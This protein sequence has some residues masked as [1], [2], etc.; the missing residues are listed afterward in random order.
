[1]HTVILVIHLIVTVALIGVIM[2]QRSEG[3]AL[4]IGGGGGAGNLFSARGVGNA[5]TRATAFLAVAFFITSI[6]LT[7]MV[8]RSQPAGSVFDQAPAQGQAAPGEAPAA[9]AGS[10]L[11]N[12]PASPPA[13]TAPA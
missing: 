8:T 11:P 13:E 4:G 12:L 2:L 7:L 9:P 3:G 6:T 1:M 10:V 5:L